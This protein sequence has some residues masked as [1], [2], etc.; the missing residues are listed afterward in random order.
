MGHANAIPAA[1]IPGKTDR[2]GGIRRMAPKI[3]PLRLKFG[4]SIVGAWRVG[5]ERFVW[6]LK[7]E[8]PSKSFDE[9]EKAYYDSDGDSARPDEGSLARGNSHDD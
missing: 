8:H 2:D 9:A 3:Y 5:A 4:F 1:P 6:I 7:W